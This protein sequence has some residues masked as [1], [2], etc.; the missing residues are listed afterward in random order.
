MNQSL[1]ERGNLKQRKVCCICCWRE[2]VHIIE[3][4]RDE[5]NIEV[6]TKSVKELQAQVDELQ[7]KLVMSEQAIDNKDGELRAAQDVLKR[8][9]E[10]AESDL[11]AIS[12]Q[13]MDY[14]MESAYFIKL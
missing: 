14:C 4:G 11:H 8:A 6:T 3:E 10:E 2:T 12:K 13:R 7:Q 1:S 5:E 9:K